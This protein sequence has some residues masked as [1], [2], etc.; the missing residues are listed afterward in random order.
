[1]DA[2]RGKGKARARNGMAD[3]DGPF[4]VRLPG[5]R[6]AAPKCWK[7]L[8]TSARSAPYE[9]TWAATAGLAPTPLTLWQ[10]ENR[11]PLCSNCFDESAP[12]RGARRVRH[13]VT[14]LLTGQAPL[15]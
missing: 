1:M 7:R 3:P 2:S 9:S 15:A 5:P 13:L 8:G 6:V 10:S 12:C 4:Q 14:T 11:N